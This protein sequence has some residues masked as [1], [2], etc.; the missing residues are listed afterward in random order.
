VSRDGVSLR[1]LTGTYAGRE[2]LMSTFAVTDIGCGSR[3]TS[4]MGTIG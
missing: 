4:H 3:P 1:G 2:V